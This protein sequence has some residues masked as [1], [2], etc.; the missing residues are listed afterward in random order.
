MRWFAANS[1]FRDDT[2]L[3]SGARIDELLDD[4]EGVADA[5]H[6]FALHRPAPLVTGDDEK[7]PRLSSNGLVILLEDRNRVGAIVLAALTDALQRPAVEA[8]CELDQAPVHFTV[9]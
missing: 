2:T 6:P 5:D 7:V 8:S 4:Y 1:S 3:R 9:Q